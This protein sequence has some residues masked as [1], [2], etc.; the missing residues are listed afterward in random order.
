MQVL[1]P[2]VLVYPIQPVDPEI[3][4]AYAMGRLAEVVTED[5]VEELLGVPNHAMPEPEPIAMAPPPEDFLARDIVTNAKQ[6]MT[7]VADR[8]GIAGA[9]QMDV[10]VHADKGEIIVIDV[11]TV[12]DLASD[13][14]L[15]QQ[16]SHQPSCCCKDMHS[17]DISSV[18]YTAS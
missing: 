12:P 1:T 17:Q 7:M 18:G 5:Q 4:E 6:W 14:L 10:F 2:T 8:L 9:A 3:S 13:S 16:V 11:H 15:L